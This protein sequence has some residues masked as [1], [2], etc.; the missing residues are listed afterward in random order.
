LGA[1]VSAAQQYD[2]TLATPDEVDPVPGSIVD[3]QLTDTFA[4]RGN[5][6]KIAERKAPQAYQDSRLGLMIS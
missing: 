6:A 2:D 1:L 4:N 5:I 3:A